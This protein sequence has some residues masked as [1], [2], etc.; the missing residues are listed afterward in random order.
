VFVLFSIGCSLVTAGKV[1]GSKYVMNL[2]ESNFNE[3]V[4]KSEYFVVEFF[5][6][7][8]PYC[9]KF[10]PAYNRAAKKIQNESSNIKFGR[11]DVSKERALA[12]RFKIRGFPVLHLFKNGMHMKDTLV[13]RRP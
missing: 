12:R 9:Q 4:P 10:A 13:G 2:T 8:C 5:A 3:T 6:P 7:W 11:V 1:E